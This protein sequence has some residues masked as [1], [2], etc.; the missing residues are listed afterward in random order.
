MSGSSPAPKTFGVTGDAAEDAKEKIDN[1]AGSVQSMKKEVEDLSKSFEGIG[2]N[3]NQDLMTPTDEANKRFKETKDQLDEIAEKLKTQ[4]A[5]LPESGGTTEEQE[6]RLELLELEKELTQSMLDNEARLKRDLKEIDD[7]IRQE[8]F[9]ALQ[10]EN[11][12]KEKLH[13]EEMERLKAQ[14]QVQ[15]EL[16]GSTHDVFQDV[17]SA[18]T[19]EYEAIAESTTRVRDEQIKAVE[20]L[21]KEG[22]ITAEKAAARKLRIEEKY[23]AGINDYKMK[24]YKSDKVA[25]I[26]DVIFNTAMAVTKAFA[27]YGATPAGIAAAILSSTQ[28]AAQI[29][30]IQS[31]PVP[32][33]DVGGMVGNRDTMQPDQIRTQLLSGEAVLDRTTV[34]NLGGESGHYSA[35]Q[36]FG[37][38]Q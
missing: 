25:S 28:G 16:I 11:E 3:I 21:E 33:F 27:D 9:E 15:L 24:A 18:F 2:D 20:D 35:V 30:A 17:M 32:K 23:Q 5:E 13:L 19:A 12:L 7:Q 34:R 38:I 8:K 10:E 31:A 26:A 14:R 4:M 6:K 22:V 36:A 1:T 29:A 37:S